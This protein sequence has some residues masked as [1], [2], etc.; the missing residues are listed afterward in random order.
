MAISELTATR[1]EILSRVWALITLKPNH[2][3]VNTQAPVPGEP[4][5]KRVD[6]ADDD[7]GGNQLRPELGALGDA[8]RDDGRNRGGKS[9][10]EEELDHF[11]AIPGRQ[12][13][14]RGDAGNTACYRCIRVCRAWA[15]L[16]YCTGADLLQLAGA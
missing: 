14:V 16:I 1:P 11:I 12:L 7:G 5:E 15:G 8:A 4:F 9:Q 2:P 3:T 13:L 6:Q 10:Q